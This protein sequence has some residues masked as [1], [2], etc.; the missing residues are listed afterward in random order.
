LIGENHQQASYSLQ[1]SFWQHWNE[2]KP[3]SMHNALVEAIEHGN[4]TLI[5]VIDKL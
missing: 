4:K 3:C 2:E 5:I 1:T